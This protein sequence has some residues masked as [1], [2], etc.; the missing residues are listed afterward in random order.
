MECGGKRGWVSFNDAKCGMVKYCIISINKLFTS[1][2][3]NRYSIFIFFHSFIID[4][5]TFFCKGLVLLGSIVCFVISL[6]YFEVERINAY[7]YGVLMLIGTLSMLLMISSYDLLSFYVTVE[8]QSLC[9]YVLAA[10]KRQSEFSVEAG[11]KY[12][13]LGAFSSGILLFGTSLIYGFSG[14]TNFGDIGLL[15]GSDMSWTNTELGSQHGILVGIVCVSIGLLFKLSA[16]PFHMWSPDVYEG[17]P[18]AITAYFSIL[19]KIAILSICIRF[20]IETVGNGVAWQDFIL[21]S[22]IGSM[23]I[24]SLAALS[25]NKIKRIL[26]FSSIGHVGYILMGMCCS[27]IE[28]LQSVCIYVVLYICMTICI[29]TVVL[30]LQKKPLEGSSTQSTSI[31]YIHDLSI[32][33]KTNPLLALT[34]TLCLFSMAGV[35]PLAG[36]CSKF[37]L[38]FAAIASSLYIPAF[39]AIGTSCISC[40]YYIRLI[41]IMY[42]EKPVVNEWIDYDIIDKQ[43]AIVLGVTLFILVF[44]FAYP[45]PLFVYTHKLALLMAF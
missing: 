24:G 44:F 9:F 38:F 34:L 8:L 22:S 30:C 15:F 37:Y 41:K 17:S 21:L 7:E 31:R 10:S 11:L 45:A 14:S 13:F 16:A 20:L 36:F 32:L 40:F 42:F 4:D 25:Q 18:T 23:L 35:P 3:I 6:R 27:T 1:K 29:F 12:F 33:S 26:A 5:F 19:P 2:Y 43:K 39:I 28:G